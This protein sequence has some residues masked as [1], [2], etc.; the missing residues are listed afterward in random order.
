VTHRGRGP[1]SDRAAVTTEL[2]LIM[3]VLVAFLSLVV[4][5]GRLTDARSD[6]VSAASDAARV[7]S[8]Q[9]DEATAQAE[10][11]AIAADTMAGEGIECQGGPRV[12]VVPVD[13]FDEGGT[14][15]VTVECDVPADDLALL[16]LPGGAVVTV[17]EDAW[18]PI[19]AYRSED[20]P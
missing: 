13:T 11:E 16:S 2:V 8:L 19:D 20:A 15:H 9:F 5:A 14:L 4:L 18:E 10:A 3:P 7:A 6:V 1:G 12:D 17:T